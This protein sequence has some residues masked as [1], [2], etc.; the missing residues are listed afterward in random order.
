MSC[1]RPSQGQ[2]IDGNHPLRRSGQCSDPGDDAALESLGVEHRQSVA[3]MVVRR[4]AVFEQ[5][6]TAQKLAFLAAEQGDIGNSLG[7][8]Q[9][10]A[11]SQEQDLVERVSHL[12]LL[13][14]VL[15]ICE[16]AQKHKHLGDLGTIGRRVFHGCRR[17]ANRGLA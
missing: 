8:G 7:T 9:R 14:R 5:A 17:Y 1:P 6:E 4:R 13:A 12:A 2:A 11:R 3:G 10:C 16:I 15:Q